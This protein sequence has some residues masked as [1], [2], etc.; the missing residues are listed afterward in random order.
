MG[1]PAGRPFESSGGRRMVPG[2]FHPDAH[3]SS[4]PQSQIAYRL[5]GFLDNSLPFILL[6][7]WHLEEG[8]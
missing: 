4:I 7:C 5:Y 3:V 2:H 8:R 6:G 1:R